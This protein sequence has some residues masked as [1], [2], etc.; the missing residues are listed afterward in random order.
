MGTLDIKGSTPRLPRSIDDKKV[1][2]LHKKLEK[3]LAAWPAASKQLEGVAREILS[4]LGTMANAAQD[5]GREKKA[6]PELKDDCQFL[7]DAASKFGRQ[8]QDM[9]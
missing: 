5:K 7:Y 9:M 4:T 1:T 6:T 8:F 3:Q 2:D